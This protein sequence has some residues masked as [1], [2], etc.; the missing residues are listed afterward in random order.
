MATVGIRELRQN[1]SQ[2]VRRVVAGETVE[3]TQRGRAVARIVPIQTLDVLDE[4]LAEGRVTEVAE[5]L[6]DTAP[7]DLPA[8]SK[9]LSELLAEDRADER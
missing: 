8:G 3:I 5:D 6:L 2:V 9:T 7:M 4:M 1:A